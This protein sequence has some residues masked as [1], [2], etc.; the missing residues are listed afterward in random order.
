LR[1]RKFRTEW[2]RQDVVAKWRASGLSQ[3]DFCRQEGIQQW[4]LSWWKRHAGTNA[5]AAKGA[6]K[7][8]KRKSRAELKQ[9]WSAVVAAQ[10][11]SGLSVKEFCQ[12]KGVTVSTF[13]RWRLLLKAD[14]LEGAEPDENPFVQVP[15]STASKRVVPS[16]GSLE[17][18]L[19]GGGLIRVTETSPLELLARLIKILEDKC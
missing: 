1:R 19:P 18:V 8:P 7:A 10:I 3:A 4:Q 12:Q 11:A 15:P 13:K 14:G 2:E 6:K 17:I 5:Q 9:H 16:E